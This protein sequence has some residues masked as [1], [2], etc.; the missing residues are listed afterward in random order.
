M[1]KKISFCVGM[2]LTQCALAATLDPSTVLLENGPVKVTVEDFEAAMTRF[3]EYLRE[4]ARANPE[5]ILK[6][7]DAIFV[8]RTL[9]QRASAEKVED[10]ALF[11]KR[12][13]QLREGYF[14]QKYLEI[15][16]KKTVVPALEKRAEE[17]YKAD[18]KR[19]TEPARISPSHIV[20]SMQGRTPEM[21]KARAEEARAKLVAGADFTTV[22]K[23]YS[24]DPGYARHRGELGWVKAADIEP[25]LAEVAFALKPGELSQ[26]IV[27]RNGVHLV[28]VKERR[29]L[30]LRSF[31]EVKD[32]II[33]EETD[34]LRKRA[35]EA[36]IAKIRNN[37]ANTVYADRVEALK[38]HID[39]EKI[40]KAHRD[41]IEKVQTQR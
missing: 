15:V 8:N 30:M 16:E 7:I 31:A 24:D 11:R 35:T 33:E 4:E 6:V 9:A 32:A 41:A 34:R 5:T 38:S 14:A 39:P 1:L 25:A 26:P 27:T 20:I 18:P 2:M 21:A 23:Q 22:A 28:R 40:D 17:L 10:D 19:F 37:Q 12:L 3:P 36:E 29:E 13:E